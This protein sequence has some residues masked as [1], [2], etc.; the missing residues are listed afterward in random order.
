MGNIIDDVDH[1]GLT[2]KLL[3]QLRTNGKTEPGL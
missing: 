3:L 2:E 1:G